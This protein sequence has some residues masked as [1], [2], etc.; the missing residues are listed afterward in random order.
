MLTKSNI[1]HLVIKNIIPI[2]NLNH[3]EIS[4]S[5]AVSKYIDSEY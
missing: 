2:W 5:M 4:T 3:D 1:L